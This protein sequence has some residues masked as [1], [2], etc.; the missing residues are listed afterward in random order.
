MSK[1]RTDH[2]KV[3][4]LVSWLIVGIIKIENLIENF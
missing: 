3:L 2:H 1:K 4:G